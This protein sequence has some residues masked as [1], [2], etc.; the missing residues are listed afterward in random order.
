[1]QDVGNNRLEEVYRSF[2][3]LNFPL[4]GILFG[5]QGLNVVFLAFNYPAQGVDAFPGQKVGN[6]IP[7]PFQIVGNFGNFP[8]VFDHLF[9][10]LCGQEDKFVL[11]CFYIFVSLHG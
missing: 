2:R 5:L 7:L 6:G 8:T 9:F 1:M 4:D 11:C 3:G 10:V